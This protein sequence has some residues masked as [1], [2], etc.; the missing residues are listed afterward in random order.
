MFSATSALTKPRLTIAAMIVVAMLAACGTKG[1]LYLP[2]KEPAPAAKPEPAK[3]I[4]PVPE[5]TDKP[6]L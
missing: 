2:K 6:G 3:P 4:D 5:T 1:P